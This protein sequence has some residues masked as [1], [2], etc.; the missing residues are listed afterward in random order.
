MS[1]SSPT[2]PRE[3]LARL[4][5]AVETTSVPLRSGAR[6]VA[7]PVRFVAFWLAIALPFLYVPLLYGGLTGEQTTVFGSLLALNAVA[8]LVGH[9]HA[10]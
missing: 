2:V 3:R 7:T 9:G 6:L 8:L 1:N 4:R 5:E 10:Q